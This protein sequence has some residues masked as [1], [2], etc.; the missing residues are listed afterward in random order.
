MEAITRRWR[1]LLE[2]RAFTLLSDH[3]ALQAK[4]CKSQH[5]PLLNDR[6]AR[7][8]EALMPFAFDFAYLKGE[9]NVVADALS[10]CPTVVNSVT[11][12]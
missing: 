7:W 1:G 11:L 12:V 10:R 2:D 9:F 8:V 4:L 5:D 3:A 6:Q